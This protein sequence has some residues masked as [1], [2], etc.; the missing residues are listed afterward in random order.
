M[1]AI[2]QGHLM[3]IKGR[4]GKKGTINGFFLF[5]LCI[6]IYKKS[7]LTISVQADEIFKN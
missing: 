5:L 4:E 3:P 1:L 6:D 2:Y 7:I